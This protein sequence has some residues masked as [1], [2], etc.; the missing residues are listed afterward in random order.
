VFLYASEMLYLKLIV[1]KKVIYSKHC[2][3]HIFKIQI[4]KN[5]EPG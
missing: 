2:A 3:S 5:E 1:K 4:I